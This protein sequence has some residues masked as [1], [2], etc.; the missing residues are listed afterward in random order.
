VIQPTGKITFRQV[1]LK[2]TLPKQ[3]NS[4]NQLVN[5][6]R[7][8]FGVRSEDLVAVEPIGDAK[9]NPCNTIDSKATLTTLHKA[10]IQP[11]ADLLPT[12]PTQHVTFIPQDELFLVP[13]PAL[14]DANGKYLI[15][16][17]TIR[18]AS[19]IQLLQQTAVLK[20]TPKGNSTLVLGNPKTNL[21]NLPEAE[22]EAHA[23]AP[24][25]NTTAI[26][27]A[28]GTKAT[29]LQKM[30]NA[31]LIHLATHGTF[32]DRNG[33]KSALHLTPN[34]EDDG[35]LT[36]EEILSLKL[37]AD[38]VVLSACDTGRGKLSGEGVIGLSRSFI[39][40]GVP[41]VIVSLWQVPD[42]STALLMTQ[43]YKQLK[44]NP[45]KAQALR[46]AMLHTMKQYPNQPRAWAAFTLVGEA[47]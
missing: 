39:A 31:K 17:H 29:I 9:P 30:Q 27:G 15:E 6:S 45:D 40:A 4:I 13:F 26:T 34:G 11:I 18:T 42:N 12:D 14:L 33:L 10:L 1:D 20:A 46:Q 25:F 41:S 44:T 35:L 24:L 5:Q 8:A 19:S 38:L 22:K 32:D 28:D 36:A 2:A 43:F 3:C 7:V 23:I 37:N 47:Q 21:A 16:H